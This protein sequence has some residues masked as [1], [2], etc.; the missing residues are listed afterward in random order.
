MA[1]YNNSALKAGFLFLS[2]IGLSI[3]AFNAQDTPPEE[4][5]ADQQLVNKAAHALNDIVRK[6][7]PTVVSI[8]AVKTYSA[9]EGSA[10]GMPPLPWGSDEP[11]QPG[12]PPEGINPRALGVG[13]GVIIRP[14]GMI[15]TN[16]HVV[17]GSERITVTFD[18]KRK[19]SA[20]IVGIDT[21]TDLAVIQLDKQP[22]GEKNLPVLEFGDSDDIKVGDWALAIGSPY[23]L[24]RSVSF[25]IIS[26]KSR[27]EMGVLDIED[28]IQTDAAIN[29]GSSGGPLLN[30]KGEI[31]GINTAIFSQGGGFSG[32]GFA[33]PSG[34]AKE[35]AN[36]L[37]NA[38]RVIRGWIGV[39]AQ[40]LDEDLAS[41]F[42]VK[43]TEGALISDVRPESPASKSLA[44][45]DVILK[46]NGLR[47]ESSSKLKTL[48]GKT[49]I[50]KQVQLDIVRDGRPEVIK[51][52]S[53]EEPGARP[54]QLAGQAAKKG[55]RPG[56]G[57]L[58][59]AVEDVPDE[60]AHFIGKSKNAGALV[61]GVRLGSPAFDSG[62]FPGDIILNANNKEVRNAK[63]LT[64]ITKK[65]KRGDSTVLYVQR[66]ADDRLFLS[67]KM[68][69]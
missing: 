16:S 56:R 67:L 54:A 37:I 47:V 49:Q 35:V 46:A 25:G 24:I 15:L 57:S 7:M 39:T 55:D 43:G 64:Q 44:P 19:G 40:D 61:V 21:K 29:P 68:A 23:G 9:G 59:L 2:A 33:I 30:S 4:K 32:I 45:G 38:G 36:Q 65:M 20:H 51:I 50:G 14:D 60:I 31:I 22:N 28:F 11:G 34:I 6:A 17:E 53:S 27:A 62:L 58:G 13:S 63:E 12:E 8:S 52:N 18:E 26:S 5:A 69:A 66:G 10:P 41:H 48:I 1:K 3:T 42:K